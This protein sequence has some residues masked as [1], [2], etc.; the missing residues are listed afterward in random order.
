MKIR[1]KKGIIGRRGSSM[2]LGGEGFN[3]LFSGEYSAELLGANHMIIFKQNGE[4][5]YLSIDKLEEKIL[6]G[7]I[8]ILNS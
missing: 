6:K 1:I 3:M 4:K 2:P 5:S 7:E 8:I